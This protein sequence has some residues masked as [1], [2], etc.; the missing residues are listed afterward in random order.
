LT[1]EEITSEFI[2]ENQNN[3]SQFKPKSRRR[4]PYSKDE[5]ESRRSEVYRLHFEYG[6]SARKIANL[7]KVARNTINS[8]VDFWYSKIVIST[9]DFH[10]DYEVLLGIER[11]QVQRTRL[12]EQLDKAESF[13]EKIAIERFLSDL[14]SKIMNTHLRLTDSNRRAFDFATKRL[15]EWLEQ[16]NHKVRYL[17]LFDKISVSLR[18]VKQIDKIIENDHIRPK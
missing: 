16:N 9:D 12:R 18:A 7:M 13:Q 5:K 1:F 11:L 6:Y 2:K 4:G 8:D 15:N 17:T 3:L 10:P 14:D